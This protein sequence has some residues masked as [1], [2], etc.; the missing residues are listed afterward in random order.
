M[1]RHELLAALHELVQPRTYLETGVR[2]G[3]SL[4]LSRASSIGIDPAYEVTAELLCD[5]HLARTTSDEFF[6]RPEPL[7]HFPL[8]VI[9][10][11]FIDGMHLS[12]YALRDFMNIERFAGPASVIAIDDMLPRTVEEARR[13]RA[14]GGMQGP[15]TGDVYK[16]TETLR[17]LRPD[18]I[19]LEVDTRP[20]GTVVVLLA[21][22]GSDVLL[23]SYDDVIREYVV[24]DPQPVPQD[25]LD[26]SGAVQ[27]EQLLAA[28]LWSELPHLRELEP[29]RARAAMR[30]LCEASGLLSR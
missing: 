6:A 20:T 22:A 16:V 28:P 25:T 5:V 3:R 2:D 21:D 26:R 7:A 15:W 18:L 12:E 4:A 29:R 14:S 1:L 13:D 8:P 27:P 17:R 23:R 11:G 9:D 30:R 24:P 19:C 10:L